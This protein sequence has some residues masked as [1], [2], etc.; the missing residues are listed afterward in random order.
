MG[1]SGCRTATPLPEV[2]LF[3]SEWKVWQGQALWKP[4]ADRPRIAGDLIA[5]RHVNRDVLV[6][7]AN[8]PVH[9][10]TAQTGDG[11]WTIDFVER[12]HSYAGRGRPPKRFVW[13]R[14]PELLDG[15]ELPSPWEV[16][17]LEK[18]EWVLRHPKRGESIRVILY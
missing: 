11:K 1:L 6:S 7:F 16:E 10:F 3:G 13:F 5:A 12:S 8:P 9:I 15:G 14:I 18:D 17:R 4:G 2:D